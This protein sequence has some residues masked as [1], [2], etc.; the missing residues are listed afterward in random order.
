M[1]AEVQTRSPQGALALAS[2]L[3]GSSVLAQVAVLGATAI[4]SSGLQP[5]DYAVY[6][7]V[8]SVSGVS[9]SVNTMAAET[10]TPVVDEQSSGALNRA[11][12]TV[13]ALLS[14]LVL[15]IGLV[16]FLLDHQLA[17]V[18][19]LSAGC[20]FLTGAQQLLTG[21]ALRTQRQSVLASGRVTQGVTNALLLL[22]LWAAHAPG[23]LVLCL[24]W[25]LSLLVGGLV[26]LA[27]LG[28][29]GLRPQLASRDDLS[30]LRREVGAQ[31]VANLLASSVANLPGIALL[32]LGQG[33][34]AGVWALVSRF[35][36]PL[37]N[38]INNT[39][40]PLYYG[41]AASMVRAGRTREL[42]G[43]HARWMRWLVLAGAL[44]ALGSI[45]LS[46][47]VLPLLGPQWR[48]AWLPAVTAAIYYGAT[49]SC[50]P[51]SQTL[52]MLGRVRLAL[53]W[54]IV[55]FVVCGLPLLLIPVL[56]G[57]QA[58]LWW[59]IGAALTFYW[60]FW[61]Q[62][63]SLAEVQGNTGFITERDTMTETT[64]LADPPL[65]STWLRALREHLAVV[66]GIT[67]LGA[68]MGLAASFFAPTEYQASSQVILLPANA[69][70]AGEVDASAGIAQ[71]LVASYAQA[72]TSQGVMTQALQE[73]K[74]SMALDDAI[75]A[76]RVTVPANT[77]VLDIVVTDKTG[78]GA[79][80]LNNAITNQFVKQSPALMPKIS[81]GTTLIQPSVL[82]PAFVPDSPSSIG[83]KVFLVVG[84]FLGF[85]AGMALALL[86]RKS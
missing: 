49:F 25:L 60:Q 34:V 29:V 24:S 59:A 47:F 6:G 2:K 46:M 70:N 42:I 61:L 57:Q 52:Q 18:L 36:V 15:V 13:L 3:L 14:A 84:T 55:R 8:S 66:L 35:T 33:A 76:V 71:S 82:R 65:A 56:G 63:V 77:V 86:R 37:V 73:S 74:S 69:K 85:A 23:F 83:K 28:S 67:V 58:L 64:H 17:W 43:F 40:Q 62:R 22:V 48:V 19:V 50:L 12:A 21:V 5:S 9:A 39:L 68:M 78:E 30:L 7:A 31:P 26:L 79:A 72:V 51:M 16:S 75:K 32:A 45:V 81:S 54:T 41:R 1:T 11:G 20:G 44:V 4:V 38:T 27:R 10:R 53:V 80:A